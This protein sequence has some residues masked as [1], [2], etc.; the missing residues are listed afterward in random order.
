MTMIVI[1]MM[2]MILI[3]EMIKRESVKD[4]QNFVQVS[5]RFQYV[6][7]QGWPPLD[8]QSC[9]SCKCDHDNDCNDDYD[10]DDIDTGDDSKRVKD[11]Q[12]LSK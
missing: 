10:E 3:L 7:G 11:S 9:K 12:N 5:H 6:E 1:M 4:S 8:M 2:M